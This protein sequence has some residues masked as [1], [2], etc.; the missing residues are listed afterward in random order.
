M[1]APV[2]VDCDPGTDDA[3]ALA[4]V[5]IAPELDLVGLTTV[6]GNQTLEKTTANALGLLSL[7]DR[8]SVPV[9]PGFDGPISRSLVP[10]SDVHGESGLAGIDLVEAERS[11]TDRHAV[12]AIDEAATAEDDL[13]ILAVGPLTNVAI[14]L[15]RYPGLA[16]RIGEI[17]VMG[18]SVT[19]GNVTPAAEFNVHTDPEAAQLVFDAPIP[20]TMVGLD[21]TRAAR[22]GPSTNERIREIDSAA[23]DA[24]ADLIAGQIDVHDE[25]YGWSSAPI[26]DALAAAALLDRDVISTER[27]RVDVERHGEHTTGTTVCDRLGAGT[28]PAN[29]DVATAVDADRFEELLVDR[30]AGYA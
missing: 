14:A 18:G 2:L 8:P 1:A 26:H 11:A 27:M 30:L 13:T 10:A 21:V 17:V 29:V 24:V 12:D 5:A 25:R 3:I 22:I 16:D 9:S 6:A 4:L 19:G 20:V 15:R 7:Y 23:T 28:Q